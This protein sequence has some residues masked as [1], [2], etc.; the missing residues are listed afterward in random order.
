MSTTY[1]PQTDGQTEWLNQMLEQYL[2]C[3]VN[4]EQNDW[5]QHLATTKFSYNS[6]KH[7]T[8]EV[9]PF[10]MIYGYNP[11]AQHEPLSTNHF[12]ICASITSEC[13]KALQQE[14]QMDVDF[15]NERMAF[16][17][18]QR[19]G[20]EPELKKGDKVY[21]L[22]KNIQIDRPNKKLDFKKLGSYAV[23]SKKNRL[24]YEIEILDNK[25]F[26]NIFHISLLEPTPNDVRLSL[27]IVQPNIINLE[28]DNDDHE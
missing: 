16:Y 21:L 2:H 5:V 6:A 15:I 23:T 4:Y 9:S 26:F 22:Q 12:K 20:K 10:T 17:Y 7:T 18:N 28:E 14:T 3:Y 11:D 19:H 27:T 13:I 8:T 25:N 1:H 24:N